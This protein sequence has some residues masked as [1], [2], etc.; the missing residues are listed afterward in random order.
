[1][2]KVTRTFIQK[3]DQK[4]VYLYRLENGSGSYVEIYNYGGILKSFCV[5]DNS[6][7]LKDIVLGYDN[8]DQYLNSNNLYFGA[9]IGRFCSR[10]SQGRFS[11]GDRK[12]QLKKNSGDNHLHGGVKGFDKIVWDSHAKDDQDSSTLILNYRSPDGDEG[13][14]G[15]LNTEVIYRFNNFN[16]FSIT[17]KATT[18]KDTVVNLT[19][20]SYFNLNDM[21]RS[22]ITDHSLEIKSDKI[23]EIDS[24]MIPTGEILEIE[25]TPFQL[26]TPKPIQNLI[27][28]ENS[29]L[30]I[31]NG[32]DHTFLIDCS[33]GIKRAATLHSNRSGLALDILTN[34]P[35]LHLYS[36]NFI[37]DKYVGK[38][39]VAYQKRSGICFETQLYSDSPSNDKFPSPILRKGEQYN[40]T[41]IFKPYIK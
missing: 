17:Y 13:Y 38:G 12:Y 21:G 23:L 41:T 2:S 15:N 7:K 39:G 20:H 29:Q 32:Y 3:V 27:E 25:N 35:S 10:I 36:G 9:I 33:K 8:F 11:I 16:Q 26:N 40:Y 22:D 5:E 19:N 24:K 18:D 14:P 28:L 34:M 30:Q 1:M 6:G 4:D 31:G 37:S